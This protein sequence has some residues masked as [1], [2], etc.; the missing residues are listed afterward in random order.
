MSAI[1]AGRIMPGVASPPE[2]YLTKNKSGDFLDTPGQKDIY[3]GDFLGV[4]S[5]TWQFQVHPETPGGRVRTGSWGSC[6]P[7]DFSD[8]LCKGC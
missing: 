6:E 8:L 2:K 5:N 7:I 3:L 4:S 1:P